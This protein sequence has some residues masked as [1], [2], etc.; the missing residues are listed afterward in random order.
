ML[1]TNHVVYQ[2]ASAF[3]PELRLDNPK[4]RIPRKMLLLGGRFLWV[5]AHDKLSLFN[6]RHG[7][8]TRHPAVFDPFRLFSDSRQGQI[9]QNSMELREDVVKA[10]IL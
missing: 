2:L 6:D 5:V 4:K 10:S 1:E 9:V 7:R 8:G 3:T